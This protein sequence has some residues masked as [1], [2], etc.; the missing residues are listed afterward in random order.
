MESQNGIIINQA[1]D[2]IKKT[3][4]EVY[5]L[6]DDFTDLLSDYDSHFKYEE[7]YS[8]GPKSLHLTTH[9]AFL[10]KRESEGSDTNIER[11]L[12]ICV[13]F[14]DGDYIK[15][16][17]L[18]DQPEIWFGLFDVKNSTKKIRTWHLYNL[19]GIDDRKYFEDDELRIGGD[20][21]NYHWLDDDSEKDK[22]EY[23]GYFIGYPLVQIN[24]KES[25]KIVL[26]K[27]FEV[28]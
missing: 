19:L 5:R 18:K 7:E 6:K 14:H 2:I 22:E 17:N 10:Y 20:I 8:F 12:V 16:I 24:D 28:E 15:R 4:R 21:F 25:L 1:C 11:F 27:L 26:D 3:Y 13:V 9:H 23:N